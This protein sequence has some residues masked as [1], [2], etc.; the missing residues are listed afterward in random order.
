MGMSASADDSFFQEDW[1]AKGLIGIELGYMGTNYQEDSGKQDI[2][3]NPIINTKTTSSPSIG[4]KLGGESKHYRVFIEGRVWSTD[5]YNNGA[6]VG[7]ALQYLIPVAKTV[8]IFMGLNGG[9]VNTLDAQW[10]PYAG[11]DAGVNLNFSRDYGVEI[12][13]RYSATDVGSDDYGKVNAFYGAYVTAIFKFSG[14]Y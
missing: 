11:A 13:A 2:N 10:N 6:A 7:G 8:N 4:L 9:A 12:G 3:D 14:D 1:D 5:E